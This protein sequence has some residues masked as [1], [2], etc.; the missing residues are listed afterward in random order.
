MGRLKISY[1]QQRQSTGDLN[2]ANKATS[3]KME[4]N[5][6]DRN[7]LM[8]THRTLLS[9]IALLV[10][11]AVPSQAMP[12]IKSPRD[13]IH[14]LVGTLNTNDETVMVRFIQ[15]WN[16][17][18]SPASERARRWMNLV[19]EGGPFTLIS[20]GKVTGD[21]VDA[22]VVDKNATRL[23]FRLHIESK[24]NLRMVGL[25]IAPAFTV[26]GAAPDLGKWTTLT[27]LASL[28]AKKHGSP[29]MGIAIIEN[30]VPQIGVAGIR[31]VKSHDQVLPDDVWSIGSIGK[32]IC[33]TVIGRLIEMHKLSWGETLRTALPGYPMHGGYDRVTLEQI[34]HHRGG[35][36]ADLGFHD[37]EIR[38]IV[39]SAKTVTDIRSK[40]V[41]DI[42]SR[43]PEASPNE[44]FIYSNAGYA[45]LSHIAEMATG[46]SYEKLVRDLV[47]K[48]LGMG[49]SYTDV[50]SLPKGRPKGHVMS[51]SGL[52]AQDMTGPMESMMSGA[53]GGMFMSVGDLAKFGQAH[54]NGLRGKD[55]ILKSATIKRL[56]AGTPEQPPGG[57][58]Y[59]CGWGIESLPG[60]E[61]FHGHNGSNGTMRSQIAIFPNA[62]LV[63]VAIVN[64]GGE[65]EPA[66]GLEAMMA[67]ARR[68]AAK[69]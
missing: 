2:Q 40:Y 5:C 1:P 51:P 39:G 16:L 7:Q 28:V 49:H 69:R 11:P 30:G 24:P 58:L 60:L 13:L 6:Q 48:P 14:A 8:R 64:R 23:V 62:N 37:Q 52:V 56:H 20:D 61:T 18:T 25:Q 22:F 67:I 19:R 54:L 50:D 4:S 33:A 10:S 21:E 45:L 3:D 32:S 35:I 43:R 31:V 46:E 15:K 26:E 9:I 17:P 53:G 34:M 12:E 36:P 65:D 66:P 29:G 59:A 44:R 38:R 55:G 42:L 41:V 68:S 63:V 47:F 57:R 27:Q